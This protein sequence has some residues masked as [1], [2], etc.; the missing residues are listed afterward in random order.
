L[1]IAVKEIGYQKYQIKVNNYFMQLPF[2][3]SMNGKTT[4]MEIPAEGII[5]IS[6]LPPQ[7]DSNGFYLKKVIY[8]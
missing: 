1:D 5:V 4:R 8:L 6:A 3:I 7:V 2:E